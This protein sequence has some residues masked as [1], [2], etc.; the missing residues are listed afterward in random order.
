MGQGPAWKLCRKPPF[1]LKGQGRECYRECYRKSLQK[2]LPGTLQS[3]LQVAI[4][5][6]LQADTRK[7]AVPVMLALCKGNRL[8]GRKT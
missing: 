5:G 7:Q 2:R 4:P 8:K 3:A 1:L 6:T